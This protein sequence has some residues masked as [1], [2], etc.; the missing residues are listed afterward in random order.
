MF[1]GSTIHRKQFNLSY[2]VILHKK[3]N[4]IRNTIMVEKI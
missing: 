3:N 2:L 1:G 4:K